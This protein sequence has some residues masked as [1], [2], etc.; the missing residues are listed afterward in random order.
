MGPAILFHKNIK[1]APGLQL[2]DVPQFSW[3]ERK[4]HSVTKAPDLHAS[5]FPWFTPPFFHWSRQVTSQNLMGTRT[6]SL[7]PKQ[8]RQLA[9]CSLSK[10]PWGADGWVEASSVDVHG[11]I[12]LNKSSLCSVWCRKHT[13]YFC[14]PR[15][16]RS[17][18]SF[19]GG[20]VCTW[21]RKA[22]W[23][24]LLE[25]VS[26]HFTMARRSLC[27]YLNANITLSGGTHVLSNCAVHRA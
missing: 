26:L 9:G 18:A 2:G 21:L 16:N 20:A 24:T 10:S 6:A 14:F 19:G 1:E 23:H 7:S 11:L 15:E 17:H 5:H 8:R 3:R 13:E 27:F 12:S 4:T 25:V 22:A